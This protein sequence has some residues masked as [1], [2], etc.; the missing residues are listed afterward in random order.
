MLQTILQ[1]HGFLEE[2][3]NLYYLSVLRTFPQ[4]V[5]FLPTDEKND[6]FTICYWFA[7]RGMIC[8]KKV[9]LFKDGSYLG[10]KKYYLWNENLNYKKV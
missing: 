10:M 4:N 8:E 5:W 2:E 6:E 7:S 3:I 1:R 9:P